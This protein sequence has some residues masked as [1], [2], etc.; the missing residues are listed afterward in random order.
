MVR[1][2]ALAK[3]AGLSRSTLLYYEGV[4]MLNKDRWVKIMQAAGFSDE[5]M[6]NWHIQFEKMEPEAHHEFLVS[7]GIDAAEIHK[8]REWSRNQ[9]KQ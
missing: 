9:R 8:I 1:I 3:T 5:E 6:H 4:K 7:L 2:S